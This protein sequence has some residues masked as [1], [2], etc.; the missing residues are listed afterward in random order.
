[1]ATV[2]EGGAPSSLWIRDTSSGKVRR[3]LEGHTNFVYG[4]AVSPD[5][6][7]LASASADG[8]TLLWDLTRIGE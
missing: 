1:M 7:T 8:T 6:K 3:R 4:L 5:G 2:A